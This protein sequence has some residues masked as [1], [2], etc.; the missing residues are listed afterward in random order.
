MFTCSIQTFEISDLLFQTTFFL[1]F[2]EKID[3]TVQLFII[4]YKFSWPHIVKW[5]SSSE[6]I[7]KCIVINVW[8]INH[9]KFELYSFVWRFFWGHNM[10]YVGRIRA[11]IKLF[12]NVYIDCVTLCHMQMTKKT[13]FTFSFIIICILRYCSMKLLEKQWCL[14]YSKIC[15]TL[16]A[17]FCL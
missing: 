14:L 5:C 2:S 4:L 16:N 3:T 10:V 12:Q 8:I 7:T 17:I 11:Q 13:T 1:S 6:M 9:L 15:H